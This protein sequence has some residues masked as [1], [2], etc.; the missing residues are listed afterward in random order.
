MQPERDTIDHSIYK[1]GYAEQLERDNYNKTFFSN[2]P[3]QPSLE[4]NNELDL[5]HSKGKQ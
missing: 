5:T 3:R 2:N 1:N 4:N